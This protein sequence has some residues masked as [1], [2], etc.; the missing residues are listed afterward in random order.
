[1]KIQ[2]F[3]NYLQEIHAKDY[4]GLDDYMSYAFEVWLGQ[5]SNSELIEYAEEMLKKLKQEIENI[6]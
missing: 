2:T 1:M 6:Q 5:L 4:K 3:E